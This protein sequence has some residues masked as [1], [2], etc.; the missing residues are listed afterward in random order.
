MKNLMTQ[1]FYRGAEHYC[2][3]DITGDRTKYR[4]EEVTTEEVIFLTEKQINDL[5]DSNGQ[6]KKDTNMIRLV[7]CRT[8]SNRQA[9]RH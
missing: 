2:V 5:I 3:V 6:H 8:Q 7:K 1:T 4:C 9:E